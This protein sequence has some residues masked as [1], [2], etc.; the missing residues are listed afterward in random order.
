MELEKAKDIGE[1]IRYCRKRSNMT[2]QELANKAGISV[3]ALRL[4]EA[5]KS[6]PSIKQFEKIAT[7]LKLRS[8]VMENADEL[9][10]RDLLDAYDR[11]NSAGKNIAVERVQELGK[12]PEYQKQPSDTTE[13]K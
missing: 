3:N 7:A 13:D 5:G 8:G 9:L 2:Q 1:F 12:I 11:L 6:S 4:Y 10:R